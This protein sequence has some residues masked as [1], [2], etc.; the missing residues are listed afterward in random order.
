MSSK[1]PSN[2]DRRARAEQM[3]AER[4]A[5][6]R[7]SERRTRL[8]VA[9]AVLAA[10][11]VVVAAV[12][13]SQ[14]GST[15]AASATEIDQAAAVPTGVEAPSGG[16]PVGEDAAPVVLDEWIDF[17]CPACAAFAEALGP[18]INELA[19]SG[20]LRVVYHPLS[21]INEGSKAAGNAFGCAIDEGK[22]SQFYDVV[23]ANQPPESQNLTDSELIELGRQVGIDS[24]DFEAC[25]NDGSYDAWINNVQLNGQQELPQI[26]TP[27]LFIDGEEV[28]DLPATPEELVGLV[29]EAKAAG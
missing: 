27:T 4:E 5:A 19:D 28:T 23:F 22:T 21:F 9:V 1:K 16:A 20:D 8:L 17:S 10:V 15:D 29:E 18:T 7:A 12:V 11:A 3:K 26:R 24:P 13:I 25:V 14:Q 6:A 2:D